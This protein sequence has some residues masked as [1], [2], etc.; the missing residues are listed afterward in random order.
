[1]ITGRA[2]WMYRDHEKYDSN[3]LGAITH[4][5]VAAALTEAGK[6][7]PRRLGR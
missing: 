5:K 7:P 1:M 2:A 3:M 4:T 6:P